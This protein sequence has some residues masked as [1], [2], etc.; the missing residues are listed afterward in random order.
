MSSLD[1]KLPYHNFIDIFK[2][3]NNEDFKNLSLAS[4]T[5]HSY[6][7]RNEV[8]RE[9]EYDIIIDDSYL[10]KDFSLNP[11]IKRINIILSEN[12]EA[13]MLPEIMSPA[14]VVITSHMPSGRYSRSK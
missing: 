12:L 14:L 11:K 9:F 5:I 13:V 6:S 1:T 3:Q 7:K 4:K 8:V 10:D 2:K